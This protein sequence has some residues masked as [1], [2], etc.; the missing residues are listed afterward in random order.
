MPPQG[1][2]GHSLATF[3]EYPPRQMAAGFAIDQVLQKLQQGGGH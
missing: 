2:L 3:K 1:H